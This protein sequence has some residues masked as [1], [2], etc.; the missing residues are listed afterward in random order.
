MRDGSVWRLWVDSGGTF[1]DCLAIDPGGAV[2]RCKVLS[3]GALR[4]RLVRVLSP[5]RVVLE[6]PPGLPAALLGG[7]EVRALAGGQGPRIDAIERDGRTVELDAPLPTEVATG[8]DLELHSGEEAPVLAARWVTGVPFGRPLPPFAVR[9]A[10]T[11]GTNALLEGAGAPTAFFVTRGLGDL[12]EIGD[13]Q[14]PDL[15]ALKVVKPSPL[16]RAVVEV[17]ERLAADGSV[18]SPI[19]LDRVDEPARR[20]LARGIR[21]AAVALLH[22]YRD[23]EHERRLA[24]RLRDLG[25]D[26]V[27]LSSD[28]SRRIKILGR[29]RTAVADAYLSAVLSTYV[30]SVRRGLAPRSFHLMTSAGGLAAAETFRPKDSLLSGPAGGVLGAAAAGRRSGGERLLAFD[31]GGTSTDVSR[32]DGV[33][34]Y[35]DE[36]RVGDAWLAS[37]SVAVETVAAGGGSICSFDGRQLKVGPESAGASPGPACYGAGGPLTLTDVNLLLG[38]ID[39]ARFA[40]P[41]DVDAA[42]TAAGLLTRMAAGGGEE[43]VTVSDRLLAGL[44]R[45]ANEKMAA[46]VRRIAVRKGY[47]PADYWLVGFGGAGPQHAC[48]VAELLG[49]DT[50]L[51]PGDAALLSA[52]GLGA[53]RVERFAVRQILASCDEVENKLSGL[54][55][56]LE[57]EARQGLREEGI[58][59]AR[60]A[61]RLRRAHL[62]YRGQEATLEIDLPEAPERGFLATAFRHRYLDLF[63]YDPGDRVIELERLEVLVAADETHE[64][65][66]SP[67]PVE[68]ADAP[69]ACERRLHAGGEWL[70]AWAI[71]RAHLPVDEAVRGPGLVLEAHSV[72]VV[73]PGWSAST[74]AAGAIVLRRNGDAG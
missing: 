62:R 7:L 38:R 26:H 30:E 37:T 47:L 59:A 41:V 64:V 8:D 25:F 58:D 23:P 17:E 12:L 31:M 73:E 46:A 69:T 36:T 19:D 43:S 34:E 56:G 50:A 21:S 51:V 42:R 15:F 5:R 68:T 2:H 6:P 13:Q 10:S 55:K 29:A 63:G 44:L 49:I 32:F 18:V 57:E 48:A 61:V 54:L 33:L 9:L 67:I 70:E 65:S 4:A 45:I 1:T 74:D 53:A 72:T 71:E 14:R 11:R 27:S 52:V 60:A 20:L 35:R 24:R 28:L 40:F 39:P 16:Y 22:A 3:S 66:A